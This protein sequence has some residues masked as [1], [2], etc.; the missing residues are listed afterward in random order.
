MIT[1]EQKKQIIKDLVD[2]LSQQKAVVFFDYSGL[3]VNQFQEL[4][5]QLKEQNIDCQVIKKTLIDLAL[6]K[7]GLDKIEAKRLPG[8]LAL[9]FG[10]EDEVLPAKFL[11]N[12]SKEN[13]DL[14]ILAGLVGGEYLADEA[15][16]EL[17]KLP[18]KQELLARL[19]GNLAAP[20]SGFVNVL[21]GNLR[22]LIFILK[23]CNI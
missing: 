19:I 18:S 8:Q 7:A 3:K 1:K 14:K 2:K 6:K 13:Q 11:Y 23:T 5:S 9:V 10:Y 17:A 12:F 22:R 21:Q 16:I 4:R 15:V 20:V